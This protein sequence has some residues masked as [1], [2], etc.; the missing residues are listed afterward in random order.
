MTEIILGRIDNAILM[1]FD[2]LKIRL[3]FSLKNTKH[4]K[5]RENERE[6]RGKIYVRKYL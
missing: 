1:Q 3:Q 4:Q 5:E 6:K 2:A